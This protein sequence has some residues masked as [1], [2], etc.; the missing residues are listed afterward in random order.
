MNRRST[1]IVIVVLALLALGSAWVTI[2]I[3]TNRVPEQTLSSSAQIGGPFT[4][5]AADGRTVTD[6]T[7]RGK[8]LVIYFGYTFCPDA[9]PTTLNNMSEAFDKLG[10]DASKVQP[11]FIT[12][13]PKR[14]TPQ[15][16]ADYLKSFDPRIVGLTGSQAQTESVAKAYR[17]YVAPQKTGGD[18]YLVD[19]SAYIYVVNPHGKF[20]N[21]IA[22]DAA[23][24]EIAKKLREMIA[25]PGT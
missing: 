10:S 8:W 15:V 21:V 22:G 3:T 7:Y 9:C 13:D 23:G 16:M 18:D 25:H 14:D 11:L 1:L 17:V 20:V 12:V 24:A 4:L 19:H 6:Q 2:A 5:D